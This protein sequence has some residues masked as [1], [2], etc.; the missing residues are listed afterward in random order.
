MRD[1]ISIENKQFV[2]KFHKYKCKKNIK[3]F[4]VNLYGLN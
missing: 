3:T 2:K 1:P 4:F